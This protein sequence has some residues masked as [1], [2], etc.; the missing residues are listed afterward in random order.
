LDAAKEFHLQRLKKNKYKAGIIAQNLASAG[1][2]GYFSFGYPY[3]YPKH[4][5]RM[6]TNSQRPKLSVCL[7]LLPLAAIVVRPGNVSAQTP[8]LE[9]ATGAG[10]TGTGP[11]IAA[12]TVTFRNNTNNP[13]GNT[14][15][16]FTTPTTTATFTLANQQYTLPITQSATTAAL[17]F[18]AGNNLGNLQVN[19]YTYYNTM[20]TYSAPVNADFTSAATVTAGTGIDITKNYSLQ[21]FTS[22]MGLYNAGSSTSGRYYIADLTITFNN[23]VTNPV[24]HIVGLGSSYGTLGFSTELELQTPSLT[25]SRLSGS[26]ELTVSAGTKI[27]NGATTLSGTT[28]SGGASGS[29]LVTG[30]NITTLKFKVY[31]RGD[32][33]GSA[34]SSGT[35]QSGDGWMIGVSTLTALVVTL[36]LTITD[37]TATPG[38]NGAQLQWYTEADANTRFFDIESSRDAVVWQNIGMVMAT[39]NSSTSSPYRYTDGN[40]ATGNNFYRIKEVDAQGNAVYSPVKTVNSSGKASTKFFPN[41]VKDKLYI[42]SNG[43]AIQS[44]V[45][46]NSDGKESARYISPGSGNSIDMSSLP[47]GIYFVTVRYASGRAETIKVL[48]N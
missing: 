2:W 27:L 35:A 16:A 41:P 36:P 11:S 29:V 40:A 34:W 8:T 31:V 47:V 28:G 13:T 42:I 12:Q 14:F 4:Q 19:G 3:Q 43:G 44:V 33:G 6:K 24:L 26:T 45:V 23:Y 15:V 10:P 21:L 38:N 5:Y 37:F 25:L 22:V 46:T 32:G 18:G 17:L 1:Y 39:G 9:F 20:G 7:L 48:K 30:T